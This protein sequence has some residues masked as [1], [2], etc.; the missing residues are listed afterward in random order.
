MWQSAMRGL[1][2]LLIF[3]N[4]AI[5]AVVSPRADLPPFFAENHGEAPPQALY[6]AKAPG[7]AAYFSPGE[8]IFQVAG[9]QAL[10]VRFERARAS[11]PKVEAR[12]PGALNLLLG[13]EDHWR[14]GEAMYGRVVY[15]GLYTGIDMSYGAA[16]RTLKSEFVVHPGANPSAI[17]VRYQGAAGL[18]LGPDGALVIGLHGGG[19]LREEPPDVFQEHGASRVRVDARFLLDGNVVG[20]AIGRYDLTEPLIIDPAISYSTLLGGSGADAAN[21]IAV[22]STGAAYVAGFTESINFPTSNPVQNFNGGGNDVFIAKLNASGTGVVYCTYIGGSGDDRAFG[23]AVDASGA[24]Y[25]TGST[26]SQNFP[27]HSALQSSL[28]GARNAFVL[29]LSSAGNSMVYSTYLGG[30]GSDSAYGI[31]V[32]A[33]GNAYVAGDTTSLNF[34]ASSFQRSSHGG[35]DAF[36]VKLAAGEAA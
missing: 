26:T 21:A 7:L 6:F 24:A 35:Q 28:A 13:P 10:R 4:V 18:S 32:D 29:K 27:T 2:S 33:S 25:V 5:G 36:L 22:D 3:C 9:A 12:L 17:R 16:G 20:F 14:V 34:P 30:S 11:R 8:A 23:I 15:P 1:S 31:A 19:E